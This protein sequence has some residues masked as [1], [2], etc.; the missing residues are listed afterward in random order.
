V[1]DRP[2]PSSITPTEQRRRTR[3]GTGETWSLGRARQQPWDVSRIAQALGALVPDAVE[4]PRLGTRSCAAHVRRRRNTCWRPTAR[5]LPIPQPALSPAV[6]RASPEAPGAG[7]PA[8]DNQSAHRPHLI[9]S[10]LSA[11]SSR[12]C[13]G[14][15]SAH[16]RPSRSSTS[17]SLY[18]ALLDQTHTHTHTRAHRWRHCAILS[19]AI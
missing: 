1:V 14:I 2:A 11:S 10:I 6:H 19:Y 15:I 13:I 7:T 16:L 12:I 17:R 5:A 4:A 18:Y 3:A 9:T 8:C